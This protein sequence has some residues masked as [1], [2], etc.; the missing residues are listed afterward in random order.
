MYNIKAMKI[1]NTLFKL[2]LLLTALV[3]GGESVRADKVVVFEDNFNSYENITAVKK[4]WTL[5]TY[6]SH[7]NYAGSSDNKALQIASSNDKATAETPS[8]DKLDTNKAILTFKLKSSN[9]TTNVLTIQG[10]G[11]YVDGGETT[12]RKTNE[13]NVTIEITS[14][15]DNSKWS[16]VFSAVKNGGCKID[17]VVISVSASISLSPSCTDGTRY[18]GTYCNSNAFFVPSYLAVSEINVEDGKLCVTNYATGEVVP[19][20]TG[21]MVSSTSSGDHVVG[22]Y[23]GG[24]SKLGDANMLKPSGDNYINSTQMAEGTATGTKFYRLTMHNGKQI[25]FWWGAENGAAFDLAANKA[26]LA[27]PDAAAARLQSLW[28]S[29]ETESITGLNREATEDNQPVYD[30]QGRQIVT[31]K[32]ANGKLQRG[33]YIVNGRKVVR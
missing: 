21:V 22:L 32:S 7:P 27:V 24:T 6:C 20:N 23:T 15:P 11:C 12:T 18:Y 19:A 3:A 33:L 1:G 13:E 16:I 28:L 30:L 5:S 8:F 14:K 10:K 26:Y 9:S 4:V 29:D 31:L 2:I 25:G 17:D